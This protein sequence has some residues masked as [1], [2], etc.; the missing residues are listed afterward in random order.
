MLLLRRR[1]RTDQIKDALL[2]AISYA[3]DLMQDERLR[4]D[5]RSA[6]SHGAVATERVR[7]D[8]G[9]ERMM[10]RLATDKKLRKHL[11]ALVDDLDSASERLQRRRS[12]RVRNAI[13]IL[14]G[15]GAAVAVIV[16][17]ARR[18]MTDRVSSS[19]GNLEPE[20]A[21]TT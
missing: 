1:S 21:P 2:E 17:N 20:L 10:S 7:E 16:P 11:R 5:V 13:V 3:S 6:Y 15:T 12:H 19:E 9:T 4:S 8:I 14:A 18:W